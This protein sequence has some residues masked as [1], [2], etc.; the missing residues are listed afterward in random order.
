M[1]SAIRI[2][3]AFDAE[4]AGYL[5]FDI[6]G[7]RPRSEHRKRQS[8]GGARQEPGAPPHQRTRF[9][10]VFVKSRSFRSVRNWKSDQCM[11][12][13]LPVRWLTMVISEAR[14]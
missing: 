6:R 14:Q 5:D 8:G 13:L 3:P 10:P 2:P 12:V 11:T 9:S 1:L 7:L 4:P